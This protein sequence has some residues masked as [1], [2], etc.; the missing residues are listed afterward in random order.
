MRGKSVPFH[1]RIEHFDRR[2][3]FAIFVDELVMAGGVLVDVVVSRCVENEV[4]GHVPIADV[5]R[6]IE[7]LSQRTAGEKDDAGMTGQMRLA[8]RDQRR[9]REVAAILEREKDVMSKHGFRFF[10]GEINSRRDTVRP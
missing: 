10:R 5:H 3:A 4:Q 8:S 9:F 1:D 2:P 6:A 7:F